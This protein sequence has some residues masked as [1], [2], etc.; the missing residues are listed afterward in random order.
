MS[1]LRVLLLSVI[2]LFLI[3][4]SYAFDR[5]GF[6]P[7]AP[8]GIFST[9]STDSP[10]QNQVAIDVGIDIT[11][12]PNMNRLNLNISYGLIDNIEIIAGL[13][14][15]FKYSNSFEQKGFEDIKFGIKHRIIEESTY[16]PSLGYLVY[17][18]GESGKEEFSTEGGLGGGIILSKKIGPFKTHGNILYF[19]AGKKELNESWNL[20][21]ATEL[22]L[23]YNSKMLLEILGRKSIETNKIDLLEWRFGYRVKITDFSYSTLGIGFDIKNRN[24]DMR[25]I[26]S[27]SFVLPKDKPNF[28]RI[29][30]DEY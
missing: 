21:L 9:F 13:P 1:L 17:V 22:L 14:Y 11:R 15:I 3:S 18:A 23:S 27:I 26:F 6:S 25:F 4:N 29:V 28:K 12:E 20:N 30:V 2:P 7:T 19:K 16:L 10:R 24:P 5:K 8:F